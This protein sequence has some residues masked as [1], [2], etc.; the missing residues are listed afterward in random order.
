MDEDKTVIIA[1]ISQLS[2]FALRVAK[3]FLDAGYHKIGLL[4]L[5]QELADE[6]KQELCDH[7]E[8]TAEIVGLA[9]D[10]TFPESLGLA[11]HTIRSQLGAWHVFINL[12]SSGE[13][14]SRT[15]IQ[16][17]DEDEWWYIFERN[18]KS[19]HHIA[20]HFFPKKRNNATFLNVLSSNIGGAPDG[21]NSAVSASQVAAARVL[22]FLGKENEASGLRAINV[23]VRP[24]DDSVPTAY[25]PED[26]LLWCTKPEA[27]FL[28][29]RTISAIATPERLMETKSSIE[30][31]GNALT[32]GLTGFSTYQTHIEGSMTWTAGPQ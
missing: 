32:I 4:G 28:S 2:G 21:K 14:S 6:I 13:E 15:T 18:V 9:V 20:R 22:E 10:P 19:M 3:S 26:F 16:G 25:S 29:G 23:H 17:S 31:Q 27:G 11:S 7:A 5:T 8:E 12:L 24:A 1:G 30:S